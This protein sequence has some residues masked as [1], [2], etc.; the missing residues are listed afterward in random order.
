MLQLLHE[1]GRK[2]TL[3]KQE[4]VRDMLGISDLFV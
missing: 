3:V 2:I 1:E 4:E